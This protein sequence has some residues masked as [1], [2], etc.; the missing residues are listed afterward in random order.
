MKKII[1]IVIISLFL[2]LFVSC[3]END[4]KITVEEKELV[5]EINQSIDINAKILKDN[6]E[7]NLDYLLTI[8][9]ENSKYLLIEDHKITGIKIGSVILRV[10]LKDNK[11]AYTDIKIV[12]TEQKI[13][14]KEIIFEDGQEFTLYLQESKL[15][16][17]IITPSNYNQSDLIWKSNDESIVKVNNGIVTGLNYGETNIIYTDNISKVTGSILVKVIKKPLKQITISTKDQIYIEDDYS[18]NLI[19]LTFIPL[20]SDTNINDI[21]F[22]SSDETILE[23]IKENNSFY[24]KGINPGK[25]DIYLTSPKGYISEKKSIEVIHHIDSIGLASIET[26][27]NE[28]NLEILKN[29]IKNYDI[30]INPLFTNNDLLVTC[31]NNNINIVFNE[32]EMTLEVTGLKIGKSLITIK[33]PHSLTVLKINIEIMDNEIN[34]DVIKI[35]SQKEFSL[36]EIKKL[37]ETLKVDL[38]VIS[39]PKEIEEVKKIINS[40]DFDGDFICLSQNTLLDDLSGFEI[41]NQNKDL[42]GLIYNKELFDNVLSPINMYNHQKWNYSDF[43]KF[44]DETKTKINGNTNLFL[45]SLISRICI[46]NETNIIDSEESKKLL[47][48][49]ETLNK[50]Y[51]SNDESDKCLKIGYL[52]EINLLNNNYEFVPFPYI[53]EST[54]E[55]NYQNDYLCLSKLSNNLSKY[56]FDVMV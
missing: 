40:N 2:L 48:F 17:P 7:V 26:N 29:T 16:H 19:D 10:S 47:S 18:Q 42:F 56:I 49:I 35:Y 51:L 27:N 4:Y 43:I 28:I 6:Q 32:K 25:A 33:D 36:Q 3:N 20:D 30:V 24:L 54:Q 37:K 12:I 22:I 46:E 13:N 55:I 8:E 23:V 41:V 15:L 11:D 34:N 21:T 45:S 14:I 5:I 38:Q 9:D 50:N 1:N 52:S 53:E 39:L 44:L 31:D